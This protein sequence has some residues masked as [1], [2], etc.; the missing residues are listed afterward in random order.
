MEDKFAKQLLNGFADVRL[1]PA[2][3]AWIVQTGANGPIHDKIER[4]IYYY[5]SFQGESHELPYV[6]QVGGSVT[7]VLSDPLGESP[8]SGGW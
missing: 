3:L 5:M 2:H 1:N 4:F 8:G 7:I 6:R